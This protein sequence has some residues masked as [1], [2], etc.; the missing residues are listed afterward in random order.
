MA[1]NI[2]TIYQQLLEN[3]WKMNEIDET[4]IF[5][6]LR[7]LNSKHAKEEKVTKVGANESLIGAITGKDPRAT[8]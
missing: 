1:E 8:G 3:G 2:D 7:I 4:E 5:E 6:L